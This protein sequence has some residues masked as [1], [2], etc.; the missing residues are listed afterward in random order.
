L[1]IVRFTT[2]E[3]RGQIT[4]DGDDS[5]MSVFDLDDD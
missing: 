1:R 3:E 2:A 5:I 4:C